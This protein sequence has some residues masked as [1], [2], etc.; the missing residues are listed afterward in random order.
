MNGVAVV[1]GVRTEGCAFAV[2]VGRGYVAKGPKNPNLT[3]GTFAKGTTVRNTHAV[4]GR[5]AQLK[6]QDMAYLPKELLAQVSAR[7]ESNGKVARGPSISAVLHHAP[8]VQV[9]NVCYEGFTRRPEIVTGEHKVTEDTWTWLK[10][11]GK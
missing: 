7:T 1:D 6:A 10:E 11:N 8:D 4:F 9:E 5:R 2:K 3:G